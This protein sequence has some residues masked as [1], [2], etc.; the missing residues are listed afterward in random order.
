[1]LKLTPSL[2]FL[3]LS[4]LTHSPTSNPVERIHNLFPSSIQILER[5]TLCV[6]VVGYSS[7]THPM[8]WSPWQSLDAFFADTNRFPSLRQVSFIPE[9]PPEV[10]RTEEITTLIQAHF[11]L[12][13]GDHKL[14]V[15]IARGDDY[16]LI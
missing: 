7:S 6:G 9:F 8:F 3:S 11:P 1:M 4:R 12:L 16:R 2:Q 14:I 13:L 10:E 15:K 5:I